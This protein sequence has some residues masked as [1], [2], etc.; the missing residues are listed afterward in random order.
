MFAN[1]C[2]GRLKY[3]STTAAIV[4]AGLTLSFILD[5][6]GHRYMSRRQ[7]QS[8][9]GSSY[10]N[11]HTSLGGV[12][13]KAT[14]GAPRGGGHFIPAAGEDAEAARE[15]H[16]RPTMFEVLL[17]EAGIIFHSLCRALLISFVVPQHTT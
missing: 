13:E 17:L 9:A 8:Q 3:E 4:M 10:E 12:A 7:R 5:Y 15:R 6:F 1:P 2:L 16:A 14:V 11:G